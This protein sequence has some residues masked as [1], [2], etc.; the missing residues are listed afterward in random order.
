METQPDLAYETWSRPGLPFKINYA[1]PVFQEIDFLVNEGYRRIP[2]GG[3]E[4]GGVLF[5]KKTDDAI[6]V[7]AFRA[8]ECEHAF[9]PSFVLSPADIERLKP[10][11]Y[12]ARTDRE[13]SGLRPLGLFVSHSR[14]D[15]TVSEHEE[16]LLNLLF[17]EDWQILLL[18]KPEKF[19]PTKFAFAVRNG[20]V[21]AGRDLAEGSFSLA[22][23]RRTERKPQSS[24]EESDTT[25]KA[26]KAS[27]K[28]KRPRRPRTPRAAPEKQSPAADAN[29]IPPTQ[30]SAPQ[31]IVPAALPGLHAPAPRMDVR[32]LVRTRG[33]A[34]II[35]TAILFFCLVACFTS[36]YWNYLQPPI[37]LHALP[38]PGGL[39]ISWIPAETSGTARAHLVVSSGEK[40]QTSELSSFEKSS[41]RSELALH[42]GDVTVELVVH[43]LFHDRHGM[44]RIVLNQ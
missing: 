18:I 11:L 33:S 29:L 1:L 4:Y 39:I 6:Q 31:Q 19:K 34:F 5:G 9:G 44:L 12:N 2:Y 40:Q 28:V 26:A 14:R 17:P 16:I 8:I 42:G 20:N 24:A 27:P 25:D 21:F 3:I 35:G 32:T 43:R 7:E 36:F 41:G 22:L 10:Q 30:I 13:L 37:Q 38:R 15:L 23:P